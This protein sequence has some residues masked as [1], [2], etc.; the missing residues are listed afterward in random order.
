MGT[1]ARANEGRHSPRVHEDVRQVTPCL[2]AELWVV[3]Q[4]VLQ[5]SRMGYLQH[6]L[7]QRHSVVEEKGNLD[8][9]RM[10]GACY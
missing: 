3:N 6:E 9:N 4:R 1:L 8:E 10:A 7:T 2:R 5:V